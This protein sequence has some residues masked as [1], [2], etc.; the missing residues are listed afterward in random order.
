[1]GCVGVNGILYVMGGWDGGFVG[2][3]HTLWAYNPATGHWTVKSP[4]PT[5]RIAFAAV[6]VNGI[7]YAIGGEITAN[8]G[9]QEIGTVEAYN[10]ATD[11]WTTKAPMPTPRLA[12]GAGVINGIIYAVGGTTERGFESTGNAL[13]TVEAYDPVADK[14]T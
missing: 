8:N 3:T 2:R 13:A 1:H 5:G 14:W 7:I 12:L 10:P 4:M 9:N 11:S 6:T